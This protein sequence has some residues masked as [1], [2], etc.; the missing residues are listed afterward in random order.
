[1]KALSFGSPPPASDRR[2]LTGPPLSSPASHRRTY[3]ASIGN[4]LPELSSPRRGEKQKDSSTTRSARLPRGQDADASVYENIASRAT[5]KQGPGDN[6][7]HEDESMESEIDAVAMDLVKSSSM[8]SL[9]GQLA[10]GQTMSAQQQQASVKSKARPPSKAS[11][12][13]KAV[14]HGELP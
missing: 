1:M 9:G 14:L 6:D 12:R 10:L 8:A 11:R 13:R 3:L 5:L 2:S 4:K 7:D